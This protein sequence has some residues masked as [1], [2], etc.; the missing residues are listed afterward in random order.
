MLPTRW[1][2]PIDSRGRKK[3]VRFASVLESEEFNDET[4]MI[5]GFPWEMRQNH[6]SMMTPLHDHFL[7]D[8]SSS[9][10]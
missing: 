8:D 7:N 3:A 1:E 10:N 4:A 9:L 5:G 6:P 2:I